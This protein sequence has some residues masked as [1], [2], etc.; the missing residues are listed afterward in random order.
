MHKTV[1]EEY[2][3]KEKTYYYYKSQDPNY[4]YIRENHLNYAV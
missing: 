1:L 2:R 3:F 4:S